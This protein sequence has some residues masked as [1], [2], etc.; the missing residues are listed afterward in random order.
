MLATNRLKQFVDDIGQQAELVICDCPPVL[1]V[2]DNLFLA[3]AV[4]AVII[5]A[6][7]G[8]TRCRDLERTRA[9]LEGAGARVLG[10]VINELPASILRRQ[11]N[12]YYR[13]YVG[14][15]SDE[16]VTHS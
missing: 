10:V 7:A 9:L 11:Y 16:A 12:H 13:R 1:L 6:K 15:K 8:A 2:P 4:D 14:A 5:V 3:A